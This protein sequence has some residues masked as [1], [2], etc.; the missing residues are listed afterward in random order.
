VESESEDSSSQLGSVPIVSA[1]ILDG[2]VV[3]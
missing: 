2:P 1:D 3:Q